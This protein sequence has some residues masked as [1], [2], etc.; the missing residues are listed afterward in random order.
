M[1]IIPGIREDDAAENSIMQTISIAVSAILI[2]AG[3]I[4][5]PSLINNARDV[6]AKQDL[7]NI[8][9]AQEY[10]I[11]NDGYYYSNLL[12]GEDNSL[13][14]AVRGSGV[15]AAADRPAGSVRYTTASGVYSHAVV[16]QLED[17]TWQYL[18]KAISL[19]GKSFYRSSESTFI[20]EDPNDPHL[21][22][23]VATCLTDEVTEPLIEAQP[24]NGGAPIPGDDGDGSDTPGDGD[25]SDTGSQPGNGSGDGSDTGTDPNTNPVHEDD[26]NADGTMILTWDTRFCGSPVLP[27]GGPVVDG[28]VNWGDGVTTALKPL[29]THS[30][31]APSA[32]T[33]ITIKGKFSTY[34]A[35]PVG[36]PTCLTG[37]TKWENTGTTSAA[38]AFSNADKLLTV[39]ASIP[40]TITNMS[41]MFEQT[42]TFVGSNIG[43]WDTSHVTD[44]SNMFYGAKVFNADLNRWNT[45]KVT[46]LEGTF[47]AAPK[48]N[49]AV[50]T[51]NTA[52]VT[53][54]RNTFREATNFNQPVGTWNTA[55]VTD[56]TTTFYGANY[57]NQPLNDWNV[58][59]VTS[60][61][62]TFYNAWTFNQPLNRWNTASVGNMS[63]TFLSASQF[64][65][66]I[67]GWNVANASVH[68]GFAGGSRLMI[69]QHTQ[70]LPHFA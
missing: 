54:L 35:G 9:L 63:Q 20:S 24:H 55:K 22:N 70:Y 67:S 57:F 25:G 41:H 38:Y 14:E 5:A 12:K 48:F 47:N 46:T 18:S 45:A 53:T 27:V 69:L 37:V 43:Q 17:G 2:A 15:S 59:R 6:N 3:L 62:S 26:P 49:G 51:W 21:V 39:P 40:S 13:W 4:T 11:A 10:A 7:A 64:D 16:C 66:D 19:S 61:A 31:S 8:A 42:D 33:V 65:Q 34:G 58:A 68:D 36:T 56:L 23:G 1:S 28:T 52:N 29:A 30:Y 50:S 60:L 44:M 32:N